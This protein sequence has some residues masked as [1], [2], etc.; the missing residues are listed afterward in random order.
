MTNKFIQLNLLFTALVFIVS[1]G[2]KDKGGEKNSS[3]LPEHSYRST[4][5]TTSLTTGE[6]S[7]KELI[8]FCGSNVSESSPVPEGGRARLEL[9]IYLDFA[10]R[11]S[12]DVYI[13]EIVSE[14]DGSG[15]GI[16]ELDV[17]SNLTFEELSNGAREGAY[18]LLTN[19]KSKGT[20]QDTKL[21]LTPAG[22][23]VL[24]AAYVKENEDARTKVT[25]KGLL[26]GEFMVC[27]R[28]GQ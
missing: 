21:D 5:T 24:R 9:G 8:G 15:I 13:N 7:E 10:D 19:E 16:K 11:S 18:R 22:T 17:A 25:L 27:K 6:K 1:C 14:S 23:V 4:I 20:A 28:V 26:D 3:P 12:T 2:K